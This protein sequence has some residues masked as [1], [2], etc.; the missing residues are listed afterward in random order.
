MRIEDFRRERVRVSRFS[1]IHVGKNNY[2]VPSQL[3]GMEVDLRLHAETIEVW[4]GEERIITMERLRGVGHALI[5]YRH[6]IWSLVR[7]PGAFARYQ[8]R[9]ALFPTLT[10]RRAYDALCAHAG[11]RADVEYVRILHLA[12]STSEAAVDQALQELL[13][14]DALRDYA[15]VRAA[16]R[17]ETIEVPS[18]TIEEP[19]LSSYDTLA[20]AGGEA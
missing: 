18:S 19:D 12:A 11:G 15:Q 6:M 5:D 13:A 17:P 14:K 4:L 16:V 7:K 8:F 9:E 1:T 20:S 3:V 10:F 2:S